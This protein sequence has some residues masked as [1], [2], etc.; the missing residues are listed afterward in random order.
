M[1]ALSH[2]SSVTTQPLHFTEISRQ[3]LGLHHTANKKTTK[4][5]YLTRYYLDKFTSVTD[6][7]WLI[8]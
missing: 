5:Y 7:Y 2:C 6:A 3:L 1:G 8:G 4:L